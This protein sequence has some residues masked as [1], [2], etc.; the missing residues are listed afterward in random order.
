MFYMADLLEK[1]PCDKLNLHTMIQKNVV[2]QQNHKTMQCKLT[3]FDDPI[4]LIYPMKLVPIDLHFDL[5]FLNHDLVLL[6]VAVENE[7]AV[8]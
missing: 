8:E 4:L 6:I 3:C 2:T 5:T 7:S 1:V